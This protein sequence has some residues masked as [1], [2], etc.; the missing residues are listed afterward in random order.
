MI[1]FS[2][3]SFRRF[4][5]RI[6]FVVCDQFNTGAQIRIQHNVRSRNQ[7]RIKK[8]LDLVPCTVSI[9]L[10]LFKFYLQRGL[11]ANLRPDS[12]LTAIWKKVHEASSL[13][14][15]HIYTHSKTVGLCK[16]LPVGSLCFK[17]NLLWACSSL[18]KDKQYHLKTA[19][20]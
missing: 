17:L 11:R 2:P 13:Y 8:M 12:S 9:V 20:I 16:H 6:Q 18:H 5:A 10:N 3:L 19:M 7:D 14:V 4:A 1:L 15:M